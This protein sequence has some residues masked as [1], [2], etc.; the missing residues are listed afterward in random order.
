MIQ[1]IDLRIGNYVKDFTGRMGKVLSL[2][3][4][5]VEVKMPHSVLK[6]DSAKGFD[7]LDIEP[8]PLTPDI[9]EAAGF[10]YEQSGF[11]HNYRRSHKD[12]GYLDYYL[13]SRH[14]PAGFYKLTH[15]IGKVII[16]DQIWH[17]HQLQNLYFA[18]TRTELEISLIDHYQHKATR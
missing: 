3:E 1:A 13:L 4:K 15:V 14:D 10:E 5:S 18:L 17:L 16:A 7:G 6:V 9:L 8:I 12:G 11:Y 2:S